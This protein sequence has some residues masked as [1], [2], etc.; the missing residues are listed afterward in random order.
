MG[1]DD[2]SVAAFERRRSGAGREDYCG[3]RR[4]GDSRGHSMPLQPV[5]N[6]HHGDEPLHQRNDGTSL[7]RRAS[8]S[9]NGIDQS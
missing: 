7:C 6:E 4:D 1:E 8:S 5:A 2:A 3:Q 9:H